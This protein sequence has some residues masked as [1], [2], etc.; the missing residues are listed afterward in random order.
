MKYTQ[1]SIWNN[2][3]PIIILLLVKVYN[4][5]DLK[6]HCILSIFL[7]IFLTGNY[8]I[9]NETNT[10]NLLQNDLNQI[11][12]DYN[13]Q[14]IITGPFEATKFAQFIWQE[15]PH[16]IWFQDY[17]ASINN[18]STIREYNINFNSNIPLKN[19]LQISAY[20]NRYNN[21]TYNNKDLILVTQK[22]KEK[23]PELNNFNLDKCYD[24]LCIY[25]N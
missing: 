10:D 6:W 9:T 21:K 18:Q 15:K 2:S 14:Y 8:F 22:S 1:T 17:Q 7:I 11:T 12:T 19:Q 16:F 5:K 25:R 24:V 3:L 23:F 20:F 13:N 4:N